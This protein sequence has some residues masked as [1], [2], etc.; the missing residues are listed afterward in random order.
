MCFQLTYLIYKNALSVLR[1]PSLLLVAVQVLPREK[2][3]RTQL[4]GTSPLFS[5][6]G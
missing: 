1:P 3:L 4:G 5:R 6:A 2:A